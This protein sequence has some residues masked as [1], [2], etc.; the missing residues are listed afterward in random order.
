MAE[1]LQ[2]GEALP[3]VTHQDMANAIRAD[4]A[5]LKTEGLRGIYGI[6]VRH[7]YGVGDKQNTNPAAYRNL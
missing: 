7:V 4:A 3:E 5:S 2:Q 6:D 1:A